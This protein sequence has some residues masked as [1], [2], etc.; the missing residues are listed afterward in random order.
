MVGW[1]VGQVMKLPGVKFNAQIVPPPVNDL[2]EIEAWQRNLVGGVSLSRPT[3]TLRGRLNKEGLDLGSSAVGSDSLPMSSIG[4]VRFGGDCQ[5]SV[6]QGS[7]P[8]CVRVGV[9]RQRVDA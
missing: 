2:L 4:V 5:G 3:M 9:V 6:H 1:F 8:A 7:A